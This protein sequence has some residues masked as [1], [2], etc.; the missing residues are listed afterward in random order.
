[1]VF[2]SKIDAPAT[3]PEPQT[4]T[5]ATRSDPHAAAPPRAHPAGIDPRELRALQATRGNRYVNRLLDPP[6][7]APLQARRATQRAAEEPRR[8][9]SESR[10]AAPLRAGIE[11]LSGIAMDDVKV[12][13]NSPAPARLSAL[14]YT[15]GSDIHVAPG[16]EEHLPHE[17]WH[18]VQQKQGRVAPTVQSRGVSLNDDAS[19]EREADVMGARAARHA[20]AGSAAARPVTSARAPLQLRA[21]GPGGVVQRVV[22]PAAREA[23]KAGAKEIA[24]RKTKLQIIDDM[25][26]ALEKAA[27]ELLGNAQEFLA[28]AAKNPRIKERLD[29]ARSEVEKMRIAN[30]ILAQLR[31]E[32]AAHMA[33]RAREFAEMVAEEMLPD[34]SDYS[35]A[36]INDFVD[37]LRDTMDAA[38]VARF[39][40]AIFNGMFSG[41]SSAGLDS[42]IEHYTDTRAVIDRFEAEAART[43]EAN[44]SQLKAQYAEQM[45]TA[46]DRIA[47]ARE[48]AEKAKQLEEAVIGQI[49]EEARDAVRGLWRAK[50]K[51]YKA[52]GDVI[53]DGLG[54]PDAKISLED[55]EASAQKPIQ[56]VTEEQAKELQALRDQAE[57][58]G[59]WQIAQKLDKLMT[60][61][62]WAQE[63][64]QLAEQVSAQAAVRL[65]L[66]RTASVRAGAVAA[67]AVKGAI[68]ATTTAGTLGKAALSGAASAGTGFVVSEA[69]G[70]ALDY[71]PVDVWLGSLGEKA[72]ENVPAVKPITDFSV[73]MGQSF[74]RGLERVAAAVMT[75]V[76]T[77]ANMA[78]SLPG[79][80]YVGPPLAQATSG[81]GTGLSGA[82][83]FVGSGVKTAIHGGVFIGTLAVH[84]VTLGTVGRD[85]LA[86]SSQNARKSISG[87]G[88]GLVRVGTGL[89]SVL[90]APF[91]RSEEKED[92][93]EP[94]LDAAELDALTERWQIA[95]ARRMVQ[96]DAPSP[97]HKSADAP[98]TSTASVPD[99]KSPDASLPPHRGSLSGNLM[100]YSRLGALP[101]SGLFM[102]PR[103]TASGPLARSG[104][105]AIV[106]RGI[107]ALN[108]LRDAWRAKASDE[109]SA[110]QPPGYDDRVASI[111][112]IR[113]APDD[114]SLL[115]LQEQVDGW[116]RDAANRWEKD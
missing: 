60:A 21:T 37:K 4:R 85:T 58:S 73:R 90:T 20:A 97:E 28:A 9:R 46:K 59:D 95:M 25:D 27:P 102:G 92:E 5:Q 43:L 69:V 62:A 54:V 65:L 50:K 39:K 16:Q 68:T 81:L 13:Y 63:F 30:A 24:A 94:L 99:D 49:P 112:S 114:L 7:A 36:F 76:G 72:Y 71:I 93:P 116:L 82:L 19:L 51:V 74:N 10:L 64:G 23:I 33:R 1:M 115:A 113:Q 104:R 22:A 31:A 87:M 14:A 3:K 84:G 32:L 110:S 8:A 100:L 79:A 55:L 57:K 98:L 83:S 70:A 56:I 6:A 107:E 11:R 41:L 106:D 15:Q 2:V 96:G 47:V 103:V 86:R 77:V 34:V 108:R 29:A 45:A 101:S 80:D 18:V 67:T 48:L 42:L 52:V 105:R 78:S 44:L 66:A 111:E 109:R 35:P 26:A 91:A 88:D 40:D 75:G 61:L 38:F 89:G 12:H 17:A 53:A